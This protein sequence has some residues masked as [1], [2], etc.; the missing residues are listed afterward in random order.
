MLQAHPLVLNQMQRFIWGCVAGRN[1][2]FKQAMQP[3]TTE[4]ALPCESMTCCIRD[5]GMQCC[6]HRCRLKSPTPNN[7]E[8]TQI[9]ASQAVWPTKLL[10]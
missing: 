5:H 8:E 4:P 9:V 1:S 2:R 10:A 3:A 7:Q 6:T